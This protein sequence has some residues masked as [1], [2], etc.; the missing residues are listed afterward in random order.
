MKTLVTRCQRRAGG[1]GREGGGGREGAGGRG[2]APGHG[3][4]DL[5]VGGEDCPHE[6]TGGSIGSRH[7]FAAQDH[8]GGS[9][10]AH[11]GGEQQRTCKF[12][13]E[14]GAGEGR[15][16]RGDGRRVNGVAQQQHGNPHANSGAL[17]A[18]DNRHTT[19]N[20][21]HEKARHGQRH[22]VAGRPELPKHVVLEVGA[23]S[24]VVSASS[25]DN[26][27]C[28][29]AGGC[30]IERTRQLDVALR[31]QGVLLGGS[32]ESDGE[33]A[34]HHRQPAHIDVSARWGRGQAVVFG[35]C[36]DGQAA[37]HNSTTQM[38]A[39]LDKLCVNLGRRRREEAQPK[40]A[41][42]MPAL[43]RFR[44]HCG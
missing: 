40:L 33:R 17:H 14:T 35:H 25:Q 28:V 36:E 32:I 37:E 9:G 44:R 26:T 6:A 29:R 13:C 5:P 7:F 21:R 10:V 18:S 34:G 23:R 38:H 3:S 1:R 42:V 20:Q 41:Y 24:E 16:E 43:D 19:F 12:G 8:L 11:S 4:C 15:P 2:G 30:K 27:R 22:H 31:A 39:T